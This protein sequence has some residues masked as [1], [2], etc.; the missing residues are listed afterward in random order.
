MYKRIL[1][2][3]IAIIGA[4]VFSS[5]SYNNDKHYTLK[6]DSTIQVTIK[7]TSADGN[8]SIS[9]SLTKSIEQYLNSENETNVGKMELIQS[10]IEKGD[11]SSGSI[12]DDIKRDF[13][14]KNGYLDQ[15][16]SNKETKLIREIRA[17]T[18]WKFAGLFVFLCILSALIQ[19]Y[20]KRFEFTDINERG[21]IWSQFILV[22]L[23]YASS[24]YI[25]ISSI[26]W[27]WYSD[28]LTYL[29]LFNF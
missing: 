6:K 11:N 17:D 4:I 24:V 3:L 16:L 29:K 1:Y 2:T 14:I 22:V 28:Y 7:N 10:M 13:L 15:V 25:F 8:L 9:P 27:I 18:F 19:K 26:E 5:F 21:L 20:K 12:V 23:F